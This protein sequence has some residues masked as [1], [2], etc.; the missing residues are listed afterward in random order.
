MLPPRAWIAIILGFIGIVF[1][2]DPFHTPFDKYDLLG[3]ASGIGAAL[4]YT[5][6]RELKRYYDTRA[7]VLSFTAVGSVGPLFL[8]VVSP[9]IDVKELDFLFGSF[10]LPKGI[11]W[12]YIVAMGLLATL[13]QIYMTKAYGVT[14]AGIVGTV[15]YSNILFS[16]AFGVFLLGDPLPGSIKILGIILIVVSGILIARR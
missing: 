11:E 15:S 12:G 5:S 13:A 4:A 1:I 6:V 8:M 2:T 14:K 7:I 9:Y 10:V 3:I 16:I